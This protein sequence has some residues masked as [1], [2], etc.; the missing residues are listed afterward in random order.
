MIDVVDFI[1][2]SAGPQFGRLTGGVVDIHSRA[3]RAEDTEDWKG[4]FN[5]QLWESNGIV[6]GPMLGGTL[7]LAVESFSR[8]YPRV[9][10]QFDEVAVKALEQQVLAG[11]PAGS[12]GAT[13]VSRQE[14]I[15]LL[16][17]NLSYQFV[18]SYQALGQI[19]YRSVIFV[20]CPD[21]QLV[22]RFSA[23]K[24]VFD[25]LNRS[26]RQSLYSWTWAEPSKTAAIA[27]SN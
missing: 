6:R 12:Q 14:N 19:F 9:V 21:Q 5:M 26:F 1:P 16:Y 24:A 2:G 22:F 10:L 3:M 13:V 15:I 23:P 25:N 18:V 7:S 20:N 11:L 4:R 27:Q 8:Q 17:Q